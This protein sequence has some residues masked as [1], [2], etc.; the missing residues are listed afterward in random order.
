MA[1]HPLLLVTEGIKNYIYSFIAYV[2]S[3]EYTVLGK[4]KLLT[5]GFAPSN[6]YKIKVRYSN[7]FI[8]NTIKTAIPKNSLM[9]ILTQHRRSCQQR[10]GQTQEQ[11]HCCRYI[12]WLHAG[13]GQEQKGTPTRQAISEQM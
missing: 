1:V 12:R 2:F 8:S 9:R 6:V 5:E 4:N 3:V 7:L 11:I 10:C 13:T